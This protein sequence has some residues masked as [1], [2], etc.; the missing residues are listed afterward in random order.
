MTELFVFTSVHLFDCS[1][2]HFPLDE[3]LPKLAAR[4]DQGV[5][6]DVKMYGINQLMPII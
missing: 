1:I 6:L 3:G 2:V 5:S 4:S